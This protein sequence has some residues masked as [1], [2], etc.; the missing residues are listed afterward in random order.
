M[1]AKGA[2]M[3]KFFIV[4]SF[5]LSL[6]SLTGTGFPEEK[7][8]EALFKVNCAS[9]HPQG[10]NILNPKKT[11]SRKD[12]EANNIISA[13]D[14]INK[15]RNPGPVPTHPQEWA[16]MKMFDKDKISDDEAQKIAEYILTTFE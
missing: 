13:A 8:G 3:R 10:G 6:V 11:L 2:V 15:M 4:C 5:F 7:T 1:H 16:G 9:C 14:I 12:R